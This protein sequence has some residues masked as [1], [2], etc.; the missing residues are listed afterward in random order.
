MSA[1]TWWASADAVCVALSIQRLGGDIFVEALAG[2]II[3]R[4]GRCEML[5]R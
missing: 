5:R 3:E 2:G 1:V 4:D